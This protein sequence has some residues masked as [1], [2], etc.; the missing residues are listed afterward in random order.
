MLESFQFVCRS[1]QDDLI[2]PLLFTWIYLFIF[3]MTGCRFL[4]R[5]LSFNNS[6]IRC[7]AVSCKAPNSFSV[8][9]Y[10]GFH[11]LPRSLS[12]V[13]NRKDGGT[14]ECPHSGV[15]KPRCGGGW[16]FKSNTFISSLS[17]CVT[18]KGPGLAQ[19]SGKLKCF[20]IGA[21]YPA[22]DVSLRFKV[23]RWTL[24]CRR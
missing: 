13:L 7:A 20:N 3:W 22:R 24:P 11:G 23:Y 14:R 12:D 15:C 5:E 17:H 4:G 18:D 2:A 6:A 19:Q 1:E 21:L 9:T 16:G 10:G 8:T